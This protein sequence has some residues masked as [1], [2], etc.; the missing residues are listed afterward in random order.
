MIKDT[1]KT[2]AERFRRKFE[3]RQEDVAHGAGMGISSYVRLEKGNPEH[4]QKT[5]YEFLK[6][7]ANTLQC[8][9]EDILNFD[10]QAVNKEFLLDL[11]RKEG[12][13]LSGREEADALAEK[14]YSMIDNDDDFIKELQ[15]YN[16]QTAK[17]MKTNS[18]WN[19][20]V[21]RTILLAMKMGA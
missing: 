12:I 18:Q 7:I 3:L 17:Y 5:K 9:I 11:A 1:Y 4:Y 19:E 2:S 21:K 14:L 20:L 15:R 6:G 13:K 8:D 10:S 16:L